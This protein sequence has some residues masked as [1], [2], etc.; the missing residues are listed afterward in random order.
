MYTSTIWANPYELKHVSEKKQ[1]EHFD[2]TPLMK[3]VKK[4]KTSTVSIFDIFFRAF[5]LR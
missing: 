4:E 3:S 1:I 2:D 5:A